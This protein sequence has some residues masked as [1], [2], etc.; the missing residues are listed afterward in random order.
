M[1]KSWCLLNFRWSE[2][3]HYVV[4]FL[5]NSVLLSNNNATRTYTHTHT[6]THQTQLWDSVAPTHSCQ[7]PSHVIHSLPW[8]P[9]CPGQ[10]QVILDEQNWQPFSLSAWGCMCKPIAVSQKQWGAIVCVC[11]CVCVCVVWSKL[12]KAPQFFWQ[13]AATP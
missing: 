5:C 8:L 7:L 10:P 3:T 12:T 9:L 2:L 1:L 6:H 13:Y 4:V 11:V